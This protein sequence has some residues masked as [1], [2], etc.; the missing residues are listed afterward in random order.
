MISVEKLYKSYGTVEA[1]RDLSF[2]VRKGEVV[3]FLGPNGAGKSTTLR[4]VAGFL[5]ANRGR[6]LINGHDI[7]AEPFEARSCIGYMP[8]NVPLY[9]ELRVSEY[10]RF[11]AELKRV[12]RADRAEA[13]RRVMR[14]VRVED[15]ADVVIAKLSKGYRQRVGLADA[16]IAS[17]PVLVL[18]EPTAGLDPNQIR[19]VRELIRGLAA[20]HTVLLSTHILT[21]VEATCDRALVIHK[22]RLVAQGALEEL[23]KLRETSTTHFVVRGDA[24]KALDVLEAQQGASKVRKRKDS[25]EEVSVLDVTWKGAP[26]ATPDKVEH[27][28][29]AL[30]GAGIAV[31]EASPRKASL[32][33]VFSLL[34]EEDAHSDHGSDR[35]G[36]AK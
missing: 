11:R 33:E 6:V 10:L 32:E 12:R 35:D 27:A 15:H 17:P 3:G 16:L 28:V 21:E 31:R 36:E 7:V 8:E 22:G 4:I 20:E 9:P 29:A 5:G 30:V 18:D 24:Q 1:V 25:A 26:E 23:S 2:E 13:V 19:E 34:T 14:N